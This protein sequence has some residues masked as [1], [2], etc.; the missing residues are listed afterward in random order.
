MAGIAATPIKQEMRS[1]CTRNSIVN[2]MSWLFF[3][4][5]QRNQQLRKKT[6]KSHVLGEY[7]R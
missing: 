3:G 2:S 4:K 5:R 1:G 6:C 7:F